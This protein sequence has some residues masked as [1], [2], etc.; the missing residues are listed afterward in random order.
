MIYSRKN[1]SLYSFK[2]SDKAKAQFMTANL[3]QQTDKG[4]TFTVKRISELQNLLSSV[5]KKSVISFIN[6]ITPA[7]AALF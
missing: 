4:Y 6:A 5:D 1:L 7:I 2:T 3:N